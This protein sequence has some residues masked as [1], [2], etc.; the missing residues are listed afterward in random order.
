MFMDGLEEFYKSFMEKI[1]F[2]LTNE[3]LDKNVSN[4]TSYCLIY[5]AAVLLINASKQEIKIETFTENRHR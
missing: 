1:N 5:T 3:K 4:K 2:I